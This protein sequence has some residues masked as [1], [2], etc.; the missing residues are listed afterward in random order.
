[1]IDLVNI[2][3][4]RRHVTENIADRFCGYGNLACRR[5]FSASWHGVCI[6]VVDGDTIDV[7]RE[8]ERVRIRLAVVDAP[9]VGQDGYAEAKAYVAEKALGRRVL[10]HELGRAAHG[11]VAA[12]VLIDNTPVNLE[13]VKQGHG[14]VAEPYCRDGSLSMWAYYQ[15]Q[16]E[17]MA[18]GIWARPAPLP[19]WEYRRMDAA[20][21]G[22][23]RHG[24]FDEDAPYRG[25][26][27]SRIFH[28]SSCRHFSAVNNKATF[29]TRTSAVA[30]GFRPCKQCDP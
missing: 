26:I 17:R 10:V 16:A 8:Q 21:R 5:A 4:R 7:L 19:P 20:A 14:M 25:N 28:E 13:I 15:R 3:S 22:A 23:A 1:M 27:R 6:D 12:M 18:V 9:E 11:R 24:G 2:Q 30:G 29:P